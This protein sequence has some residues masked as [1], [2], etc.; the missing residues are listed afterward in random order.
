MSRSVLRSVL[1]GT[2]LL[3]SASLVGCVDAEPESSESTDLIGEELVAAD[4]TEL[5]VGSAEVAETFEFE[6]GDVEESAPVAPPGADKLEP[7]PIPWVPKT[8]PADPDPEPE[9]APATVPT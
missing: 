1:L 2:S 6:G 8:K 4:E 3:L 9:S 7:E 5:D